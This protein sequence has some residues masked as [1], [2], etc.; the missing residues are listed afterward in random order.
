VG[1]AIAADL[2]FAP[3][4]ITAD[5][6]AR[7]G[8]VNRAIPDEE[9]NDQVMAYAR[10][11]ARDSAPRSLAVMKAQIWGYE[12]MSY[13][14]A[15]ANTDREIGINMQTEDFREAISSFVRKESPDFKGR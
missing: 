4:K 13:D 15:L 5:E 3:R 14:E 12:T 11:L 10:Q 8:L 7:M 9:F 1:P 2:L 6:A